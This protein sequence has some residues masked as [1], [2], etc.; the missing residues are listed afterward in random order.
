[1]KK[2]IL[3][4]TS[5]RR[6]MILED[7]GLKFEI[8]ASDFEE[9]LE[10]L[11]FT[12][13]KIENLAYCKAEAV[14]NSIS[15]SALIISADTVVVLDCKILGKPKDS[16]DAEKMLNMLSGKEHS[17][18]TSI[19]VIDADSKKFEV[20]SCTT[21]VEFEDFDE[22]MAKEY[23][24]NYKPLDKAGAYGIQEMPKGYVK[25]IK[26]SLENVIGLCPLVLKKILDKF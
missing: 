23:V 18:I 4:S 24:K 5:P 3:A 11:D 21:Y 13:D 9:K 26:G 17:V 10:S 12:Y 8:I 7:L 6:R 2:I 25:N 1:M 15:E 22:K 19:C 16:A 14:L 20:Q